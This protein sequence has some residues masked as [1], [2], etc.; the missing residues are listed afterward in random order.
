[1]DAVKWSLG[2][3][4]VSTV[5]FLRAKTEERHLSKDPAYVEYALWMK[6]NGWLRFLDRVPL[7]K[8]AMYHAPKVTPPPVEVVAVVAVAETVVVTGEGG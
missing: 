3:A 8:H 6:E 2:L 4:G 1:V 5:Y 7:V